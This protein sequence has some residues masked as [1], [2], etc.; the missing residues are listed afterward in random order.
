MVALQ[1]KH[2][3]ALELLQTAGRATLPVTG[4]SMFPALRP[5]DLLHIGPHGSIAEGDVV[6]YHRHGRLIA[7]RVIRHSAGCVVTRGDRLK[8]PDSPVPTS[9]ILGRV[10]GVERRGQ[11]VEARKRPVVSCLLSGSELAARILHRLSR[12]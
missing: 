5:G 11:P 8:H 4:F 10:I 12:L 1:S 2:D 3:L 7:H 9:E 6:V